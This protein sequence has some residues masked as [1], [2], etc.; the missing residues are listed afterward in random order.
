MFSLFRL[1]CFHVK[2]SADDL[3]CYLNGCFLDVISKTNHK[4][5]WCTR[6]PLLP[7]FPLHK[8]DPLCQMNWSTRAE[9]TKFSAV[10]SELGEASILSHFVHYSFLFINKI[11]KEIPS[12]PSSG[13]LNPPPPPPS[14]QHDW[15]HYN[16]KQI[17]ST[18]TDFSFWVP[19]GRHLTDS[20]VYVCGGG[21]LLASVCDRYSLAFTSVAASLWQQDTRG[22]HSLLKMI[23]NWAVFLLYFLSSCPGLVSTFEF[24][25]RLE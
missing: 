16:Q 24:S 23:L 7:P 21:G 5:F 11:S 4:A 20:G 22:C 6:A 15:W 17:S 14:F 8:V 25:L 2:G 13:L 19:A 10:K 1:A 9:Q 12:L 18:V 3:S